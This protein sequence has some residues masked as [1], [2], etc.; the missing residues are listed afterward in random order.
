M[1]HTLGYTAANINGFLKR[2]YVRGA[3]KIDTEVGF[4]LKLHEANTKAPLSPLYFNLRVPANK[5][6]PLNEMDVR[7][8]A[9]FF[10]FYLSAHDLAF[11]AICPIPHAGDPFAKALQQILTERGRPGVPILE[12]EKLKGP[13]V[14]TV[15]RLKTCAYLPAGLRVLLVDDL[16]SEAT[17]K[18]EA[19]N[20]LSREG[21]IV[22]QCLV[23]LDR[24]QGGT[25]A[26]SKVGI[27]LHSI[28]GLSNVL[29]VYKDEKLTT[30]A[31]DAVIR[32]Y[33]QQQPH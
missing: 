11:D 27:K 23:F 25:K 24:E 14:R 10:Y 21:C 9:D 13:E 20:A 1:T 33:L 17:S 32:S 5:N 12:L 19:Y 15:S 6:G 31:Q 30:P 18:I 28:V 22:T 26:L 2:L 29:E 4:E 8:I 16:I 7:E 3:V